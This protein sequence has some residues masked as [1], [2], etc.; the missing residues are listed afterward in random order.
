MGQGEAFGGQD[1]LEE[2]NSK[3]MSFRLENLEKKVH[4]LQ[5]KVNLMS[6]LELKL[7]EIEKRLEKVEN[8]L[9]RGV[10]LER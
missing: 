6:N 9:R 2:L 8:C 7:R 1:E 4:E 3:V 10:I 5:V